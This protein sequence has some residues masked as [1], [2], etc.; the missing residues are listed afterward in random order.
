MSSTANM[1]ATPD[2]VG[3]IHNDWDLQW[4]TGQPGSESATAQLVKKDGTRRLP[5]ME[6]RKMKTINIP[7]SQN[8]DILVWKVASGGAASATYTAAKAPTVDYMT[9]DA[10][11][12]VA[13]EE[14]KGKMLWVGGLG[15]GALIL[16]GLGIFIFKKSKKTTPSPAAARKNK[17]SRKRRK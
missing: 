14:A 6:Y 13:D 17:K 11:K 2:G 8:P 4:L 12:A 5:V 1:R 15:L 3:F 9:M 16:L 7:D 10:M